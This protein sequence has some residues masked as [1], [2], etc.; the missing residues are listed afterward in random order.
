MIEQ[1][2]KDL[3]LDEGLE[4]KP[5]KDS[6]GKLTIGVGRNLDDRKLTIKEMD[7]LKSNGNR[8]ERSKEAKDIFQFLVSDFKQFGITKEEALYLLNND[9]VDCIA[10]LKKNLF[11]FESK[12]DDVKRVLINMC[13][14]LGIGGLLKFKNTL[15]FIKDSDYKTASKTMLSSLWAKQVKGRAIRLSNI[16]SNV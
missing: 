16:L 13:F 11:W 2:I 4:L 12:P 8:K 14:N 10:L 3:I 9:V 1:L 15:N 7:F 6:V 5:Y